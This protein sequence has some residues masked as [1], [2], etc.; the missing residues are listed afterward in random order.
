MSRKKPSLALNKV[1]APGFLKYDLSKIPPKLRRKS[2]VCAASSSAKFVKKSAPLSIFNEELDVPNEVPPTMEEV[3]AASCSIPIEN[4]FKLYCLG[5]VESQYFCPCNGSMTVFALADFDETRKELQKHQIQT[6]RRKAVKFEGDTRWI[7]FCSCNPLHAEYVDALS[8]N[9][10]T[11]YEDFSETKCI[12]V[13]VVE[14]FTDEFD[15]ISPDVYFSEHSYGKKRD[16]GTERAVAFLCNGFV[17]LRIHASMQIYQKR[18][19]TSTWRNLSWNGSLMEELFL[20]TTY[21][22]VLLQFIQTP[23]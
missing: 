19:R 16:R 9:L 20:L 10:L 5:I 3:S 1:Q 15:D 13:R 17:G 7:C 18:E 2:N 21:S 4:N 12:H 6:V 23:G 14:K 11:S 8:A 22:P